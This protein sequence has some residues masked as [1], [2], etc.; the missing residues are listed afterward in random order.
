M[1]ECSTRKDIF[2]ND[3]FKNFLE[4]DKHSPNM[5]YNSPTI[6]YE[7]TELP[8][9]VRDFYFYEE[10]QMLYLVCCDMNITCRVDT[11]ITNVN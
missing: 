11:Y 8:L 1:K 4:L 7:N 6:V 3:T 2:S 10:M 9:G 5:T